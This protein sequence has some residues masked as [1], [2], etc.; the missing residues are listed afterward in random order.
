[1]SKMSCT[2]MVS[3]TSL[4]LASVMCGGISKAGTA[5]SLVPGIE[6]N[7]QI[8]ESLLTDVTVAGDSDFT[9]EAW[10]NPG[11]DTLPENRVMG[12]TDWSSEGRLILELRKHSS[13]DGANKAVLFYRADNA[14]Y[15][16][17][18]P[19]AVVPKDAWTHLAV[20]RSGSTLCVYVN[21]SLDSTETNYDGPLP[22]A[23]SG[24]PITFGFGYAFNG[25]LADVRLWSYVRTVD[26]I[27]SGMQ[28]RLVG[29]EPGLEGYWPMTEGAGLP[30]NAVTSAAV[31]RNGYDGT[32]EKG[33]MAW[34]TGFD[35]FESADV[36]TY[37]TTAP[38]GK[39]SEIAW[40][41][42][43]P[44]PGKGAKIVLSGAGTYEND[45]GI[46]TLNAL[47]FTKAATLTGDQ[48]V[49]AANGADSPTL[50]TTGAIVCNVNTAMRLNAPLTMTGSH[51]SG[52]LR[53]NGAISGTGDIIRAP[54][55]DKVTDY[56][57]GDNSAWSGNFDNRL[58][59]LVV[60]NGTNLGM[61]SYISTNT[62][63]NGVKRLNIYGDGNTFAC[64]L[65][66]AGTAGSS[67]GRLYLFGSTTFNGDVFVD[68]TEVYAKS[69]NSNPIAI[70]FAK[71]VSK[72]GLSASSLKF[73]S[74]GFVNGT[75]EFGGA[76]AIGG[77]LT[78][79]TGNAARPLA[80]KLSA[81]GNDFSLYDGYF[82]TTLKCESAYAYPSGKPFGSSN[83]NAGATIDVCGTSQTL[84]SYMGGTYVIANSELGTKPVV[85]ICQETDDDAAQLSTSGGLHLVKDGSA[86]LAVANS[87]FVAG[88]LEVAAGTLR[89]AVPTGYGRLADAV[90]VRQ[91][92]VLDLGGNTFACGSFILDGGEIR[93]G[94]LVS[95][96]V[97]IDGGTVA[98]AMLGA[99]C[100]AAGTVAYTMP[101]VAA[102]TLSKEGL[103]FYMPFDSAETYLKAEGP[104]NVT[105]E[106][107]ATVKNTGNN[108]T[109][110]CDTQE[111]R[112]GSGS[113]Y[114]NG[115]WPLVPTGG[116]LL[117]ETEFPASVPTGNHPYT[118]AFF[119]KI[120]ATSKSYAAGM[121]GYGKR[122]TGLS[123]NYSM[124]N[125][126]S[127]GY[128]Y[129]ATINNY[130][131]GRDARFELGH[132][133]SRQDGEWHSIVSTWDGSVCRLYD[134]GVEVSA[135]YSNQH[136][137]NV[138]PE[139]FWIGST[140]NGNAWLGWLDDVA[141]F[142]RAVSADEALAYHLYGVAGA[143]D[144]HVN[145]IDVAAESTLTLTT[146]DLTD[147]LALYLPF[148]SEETCLK[149]QGPDKVNFTCE[150]TPGVANQNTQGVAAYTPSGKFGA[151]CVY[152]DGKSPLVADKF[153][154]HVPTG[155][156]PYTF[157]C[158]FKATV[159]NNMMALAG[160][161]DMAS[162]KGVSFWTSNNDGRY[163]CTFTDD[164]YNNGYRVIIDT[165]VSHNDGAWH[166]FVST[167]NGETWRYWLDGAEL[168]Y[169]T[170]RGAPDIGST[171][172][173]VGGGI[174]GTRT[175]FGWLDE[176]AIWDRALSDA[177]VATYNAVGVANCRTD[178]SASVRISTGAT[179]VAP[180]GLKLAGTLT[181]AGT[182]DGDLVLADGARIVQT[183]GP[184][185]SVTGNV[186]IEGTGSFV[187][188]SLPT[189]ENNSPTWEILQTLGGFDGEA[190]AHARTWRVEGLAGK[191]KTRFSAVGT[192][193]K[194]DVLPPG[195]VIIL[196]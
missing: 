55:V 172:F 178:T 109:A 86:L 148:D 106:C 126:Q 37:T 85:R 118:V 176:V 121:I 154:A 67:G 196:R 6:K 20:T 53:L 11:S 15:R 13:T 9:W 124:I 61:S 69:E 45:L 73:G 116:T 23:L 119:Y 117:E 92:A 2:K 145:G 27:K 187:P 18:S 79:N 169:S 191:Y 89:L 101:Q 88:T 16:S 99:D 29:N 52:S 139:Y 93:N 87:F 155:A 128:D 8:T 4:M 108:G 95:D 185:P 130:Y 78:V 175:W 94:T 100:Q 63:P 134:D 125:L 183:A 58:G 26:Q 143:E 47:S 147:G 115:T 160:Y 140:L 65:R 76:L 68:N 146:C 186:T 107:K 72:A 184:T 165:G 21:G 48:L 137:P 142:N 177:E 173:Y 66:L 5:I 34:T 44:V 113:L 70:K 157:A 77:V 39:W 152:L 194:V 59:H 40:Q 180:S 189:K 75:V 64:G 168:E 182:I 97:E 138:S 133:V 74:A 123:N 50:S 7:A 188:L 159:R 129:F 162:N 49:F 102:K 51:A 144:S 181:S 193:F 141:I 131:Y 190:D 158:C 83:E 170:T 24:Y 19:T 192:L 38:G 3:V 103:V 136:V 127:L 164:Y 120:P 132:N 174:R 96:R 1:M 195:L 46:F 41:P 151:G 14:N 22:T 91:G 28:T 150:P 43:I 71:G 161:G 104:D 54:T 90:I 84:G 98:A 149:D 56:L 163:I 25:A 32:A 156:K 81:T 57:N 17:R 110:T 30:V 114:L 135:F 153:P 33:T 80:V 35:V 105:L 111:K 167:W 31:T 36:V 42:G 179:L 112:F 122:E 171:Y 166:T 12:Q 60:S 82:G 10:V 62:T